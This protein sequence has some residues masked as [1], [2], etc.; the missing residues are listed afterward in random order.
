MLELP[1]VDDLMSEY[2]VSRGVVL[3]S[4]AVLQR[5]GLAEP[6]PGSRWQVTH[7]R[8]EAD[9]QPLAERLI[10]VFRADALEVGMTFP[11]ATSLCQRFGVSRPT[12]SKALDHLESAG[13]LTEAR[14]GKP[15]TV[16]ALP[17]CDADSTH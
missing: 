1:S 17:A 5:E 2:E 4:F 12:V 9:R 10:G 6:V 14:Q 3:R 16:L 11:S 13:L 8:S 15:R 7:R